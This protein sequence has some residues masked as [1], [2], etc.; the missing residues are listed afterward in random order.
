MV[1]VMEFAGRM[2]GTYLKSLLQSAVNTTKSLFGSQLLAGYLAPEQPDR[3]DKK[4]LNTK[5]EANTR[6]LPRAIKKDT[7]YVFKP[8]SLIYSATAVE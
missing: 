7:G 4:K 8:R 5:Y 1:D 3:D 2:Y 6:H